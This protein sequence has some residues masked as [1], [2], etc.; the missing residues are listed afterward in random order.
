MPLRAPSLRR[1]LP[2]FFWLLVLALAAAGLHRRHLSRPLPWLPRAF[3]SSMPARVVWAWE[4]PEDL[5]TLSPEIGVAYLAETIF[6]QGSA[7]S[8][9]SVRPRR[10]PLRVSTGAPVMAVVRIESLPGSTHNAALALVLA[11]HL[12]QLARQK[13]GLAAFQID[14]D[15]PASEHFFYAALLQQLRR[16]LP[17]GLPLSITALMSWCGPDS[18]LSS[19]PRGTIEE[20]VPMLFRMGGPRAL[21]PVKRGPFPRMD[22]PLCRGSLGLSTDEPWPAAVRSAGQG[23]RIYVFAPGPWQPK[24]LAAIARAPLESLSDELAQPSQVIR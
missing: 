1:L 11:Q 5:R 8:H 16:Q 18:W 2:S 9:V 6:I 24:Q 12:A 19:L 17:P 22:E 14:Y 20:A 23:V 3:P 10:Q 15:A 4:E 21:T 13:T 7:T